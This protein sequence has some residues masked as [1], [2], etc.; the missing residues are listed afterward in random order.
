MAFVYRWL[1]AARPV[2]RGGVFEQYGIILAFIALA[3]IGAVMGLG[4]AI[5]EKFGEL[6][7]AFRT[8]RP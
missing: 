1:C 5:Q 4:S 8:V 3:A 6:A 7:N 2:L